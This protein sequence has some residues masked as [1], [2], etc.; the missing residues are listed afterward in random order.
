MKDLKITFD[1]RLDAEFLNSIYE[2]DIEHLMIVFTQ[3][4]KTMPAMMTEMEAAFHAG[5]VEFFRQKVH[6]VKPVFSFVGLTQ[7]TEKAEILEKKC[8]QV[9]EIFE[10]S[11][12]YEDLKNQYSQSFVIVQNEVIRL[13]ELVN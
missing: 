2:D 1:P 4:L 8:K 5:D 13:E 10:V 7:I 9:N 12:L 11:D 6:R 3:F